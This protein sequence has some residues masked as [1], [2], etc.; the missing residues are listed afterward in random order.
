MS[1][2]IEAGGSGGG[3]PKLPYLTGVG[4]SEAE[5]DKRQEAEGADLWGKGN[6]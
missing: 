4:L 6:A 5:P 1:P 2:S 3:A